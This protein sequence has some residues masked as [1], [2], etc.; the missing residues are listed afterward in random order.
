MSD[1]HGP[2]EGGGE[3]AEELLRRRFAAGEIHAD[4]YERLLEVLRRR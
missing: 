4:E 1:C 3:D 2:A